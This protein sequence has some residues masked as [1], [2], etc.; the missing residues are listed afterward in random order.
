MTGS[1]ITLSTCS[2]APNRLAN[3]TAYC[4]ARSDG[5]LKSVGSK[6][7]VSSIMADARRVLMEAGRIV[8]AGVAAIARDATTSL[9]RSTIALTSET[10]SRLAVAHLLDDRHRG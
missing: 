8:A 3:S 4:V 7:L 9:Y 10:Q 1:S 2:F 5:S 6:M